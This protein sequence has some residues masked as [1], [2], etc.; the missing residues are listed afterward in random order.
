[1]HWLKPTIWITCGLWAV[2]NIR[3]IGRVRVAQDTLVS[4]T[5]AA[6]NH[7]PTTQ[8]D[9]QLVLMLLIDIV[10]VIVFSLMIFEMK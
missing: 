5:T 2:K 9:R 6:N 7:N 3:N 4:K 1:M 8:K 10:I